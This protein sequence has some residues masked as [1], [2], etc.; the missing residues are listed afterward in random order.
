MYAEKSGTGQAEKRKQSKGSVAFVFDFVAFLYTFKVVGMKK[1]K[2]CE[3]CYRKLGGDIRLLNG[4]KLCPPCYEL[5]LMAG[6]Y[7]ES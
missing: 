5:E 6:D 7:N 1:E 3:L 4:L 2:R